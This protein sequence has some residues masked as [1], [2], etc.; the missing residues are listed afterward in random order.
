M[1][2]SFGGKCLLL[3]LIQ[4]C[5]CDRE[6]PADGRPLESGVSISDV[7]ERK[8]GAE[9][10]A[11]KG[12]EAGK[13]GN[14]GFEKAE[15]ES[16]GEKKDAARYDD[17]EKSEKSIRTDKQTAAHGQS[18]DQGSNSY[19]SHGQ[20]QYKKGYHKSG[21]S[22]NYHKDESEN[23]VSFY[24]DSEDE[25]GHRGHDNRAGYYGHRAQDDFRDDR[26]D[27]AFIARDKAR[28]ALRDNGAGYSDHRGRQGVYDDNRYYDHRRSNLRDGVGR[29][30]D[31]NGN[32]IY[33]YRQ[34]NPYRHYAYAPASHGVGSYYPRIPPRRYHYDHQAP[35]G[36][37]YPNR[38]YYPG[39]EILY[40]ERHHGKGYG[41]YYERSYGTGYKKTYLQPDTIY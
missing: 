12:G 6:G 9:Y 8:T 5:L 11:L 3:L 24:D 38:R 31:R 2:P 14:S 26:H 30:Y 34:E 39:G 25:K 19:E 17:K 27:S 33:Y 36:R 28:H 10:V 29:F 22:N 20:G 16:H 4:H 21:F 18:A 15:S 13:Q 7:T 1:F 40:P 32:E 23:K 35:R 37:Y 41:D